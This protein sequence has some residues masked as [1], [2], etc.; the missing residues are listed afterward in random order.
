MFPIKDTI[1]S[2]RFPIVNW[3]L[4]ILNVLVFLWEISLG[5]HELNR[6]IIQHGLV[7][8]RLLE[9]FDQAQITTIY[10]SMFMHGGFLHLIMNMWGL[11]IFGD[12]VEDRLGHLRYLMF[13]LLCGT[14]AAFAQVFISPDAHLPMVGASGAIAG[15]L[16]GYL[17][18]FPRSRVLTLIPIFFIPYFLEIPAVIYLGFWF[19]SQ[20]FTGVAALSPLAAAE[21]GGVAFFAHV[22]GFVAGFILVK[23]FDRGEPRSFAPD[24]RRQLYS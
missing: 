17:L 9:H 8:A 4:I 13:Y 10:T 12:N 5:S 18:L 22:G 20:L 23:L 15:I 19:L 11:G 6:A 1:P 24:Q 2:S 7:P 16:G 21:Q 14:V 3:M